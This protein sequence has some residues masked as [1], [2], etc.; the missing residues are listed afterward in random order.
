MQ[1]MKVETHETR[2]WRCCT[3]WNKTR[4]RFEKKLV[5]TSEIVNLISQKHFHVWDVLIVPKLVCTDTYSIHKLSI[6]QR[7]WTVWQTAAE[8]RWPLRYNT[9][10]MDITCIS[11]NSRQHTHAKQTEETTNHKS[12]F[13]LLYLSVLCF[14]SHYCYIPAEKKQQNHHRKF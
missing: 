14:K 11:S 10:Q 9:T 5:W 2:R 8:H 3:G 12:S 7:G 6:N 13:A 4:N 1:Q